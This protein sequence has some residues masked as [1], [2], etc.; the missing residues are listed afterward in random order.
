MTDYLNFCMDQV[1]PVKTVRCFSNNKPWITCE[2]KAVL[3]R[4][5]RAFRSRNYEEM[6]EAQKELK[7]CLKEA[8]EA[9]RRKLEI[10]LKD[11]NMREVWNGMKTITGCNS[12][13]KEMC[14]DLQRADELNTFFNRFSSPMTTSSPLQPSS[15]PPPYCHYSI[16]PPV[17][18]PLPPSCC[19]PPTSPISAD[20]VRTELRRLHPRKAAGPDRV[21]PRLLRACAAELGHPLQQVYN[22]SLR[23]GRV[24][25]LWKTSCIV[26]VP[27]KS[28]PSELNDY[29]PVALTSHV[30]KTLERL[31]LQLM[32]PQVQSV[33]DPLQFAYQEKVG[34]EDAV[35]YLLHRALSYL[36]VEG[37]TVRVLFFD[38]S[39]AFNTIQP[40]LLQ[41]KLN[42][43]AVDPQLV[44][45]ITDYLTN[46]P[47]FVRI[48]SCRSSI[49]TSST[50]APQGTVL[51]PLLFTL[52]TTDF[53]YNSDTCHLQKFSDDTAIV[54]C[55]REGE[56]GEYRSLV[57]DFGEWS[58][59]NR[60]Q[61]NISKTK[62]MVFD[63]HRAPLPPQPIIIDG[64]E[65]EMV[66]SYKYL[67]LQLDNKLGWSVNMDKVY[68]K[69]QGRMYFLR[70]L[71]SFN[72]CSKL[73]N[74]FY[75]SIVSSV[76]FYAVVCWGG[77][78]KK[79]DTQRLNRLI[80]RAGSVMGLSLDSVE[81]VVEQ[82]TLSKI[83]GILSNQSHPLYPVFSR[84]RSSISTRLHSLRCSTERFRNSFVPWAIRLYNAATAG[85]GR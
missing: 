32:R 60:L 5:K 85:R 79:K 68:K 24:P 39:S 62:E 61:L 25:S 58:Q 44:R 11:N 45:W 2:V 20:Q 53:Q 65:V 57:K 14:R 22:L 84:Q 69:G 46:R 63:F 26:P 35:L 28:R 4:K 51:S 66:C 54:A 55:I 49:L 34:V 80:K 48:G 70:R 36:D 43:M 38:F 31:V 8:K 12:K 71:A 30:M 6:R 72:V 52:Y 19:C 47:Q 78:A 33:R 74:M 3:N 1:V 50:G 42:I 59:L 13:G 75:Q 9:Y 73:L 77:S 23:L 40:H 41:D 64:K 81:T 76:I 21:C 16:P 67:G 17:P 82:R 18:C 29:R 37:S 10:K 27:K 56:E 7:I 15:G 83:R